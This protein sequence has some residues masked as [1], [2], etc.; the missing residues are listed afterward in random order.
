MSW[1]S[2]E[3]HAHAKRMTSVALNALPSKLCTKSFQ[4]RNV[5]NATTR[6]Q[7]TARREQQL[8]MLLRIN[9]DIMIL[10]V[11]VCVDNNME[12][13]MKR[14]CCIIERREHP[15]DACHTRTCVTLLRLLPTSTTTILVLNTTHLP[16]SLQGC[17]RDLPLPP[18]LPL[19]A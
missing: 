18:C 5:R 19:A 10:I 3:P 16:P 15:Y 1:T 9:A 14:C 4:N 11:I 17:K 7:R 6:V 12:Q 8:L 13:I 2:M